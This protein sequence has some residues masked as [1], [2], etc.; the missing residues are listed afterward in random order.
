MDK[1]EKKK[2]KDSCPLCEVS[3]ETVQ[4]LKNNKYFQRKQLKQEKLAKKE[5]SGK[6]KKTLK[7]SFIGAIG[8]L[9]LCGAVYGL[10]GYFSKNTVSAASEVEI[11]SKEYD[12]GSVSIN[13][14]L[15]THSFEIKNIGKGNLKISGIRTSCMCTTAKLKVGDSFSPE[16]GMH[17]SSLFWSKDIKPGETGYIEVTFDPAFHGPAGLGSITRGIYVTTDNFE[18]KEIEFLLSANVVE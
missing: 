9:V 10:Y 14:G 3:E 15:V 1:E 8:I 2:E 13:G 18:N 4:N 12:A 17:T 5:R 11:P 6:I 7:L 16:F